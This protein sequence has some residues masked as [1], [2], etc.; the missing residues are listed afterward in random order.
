MYL[1]PNPKQIH[2]HSIAPQKHSTAPLTLSIAPL[3]I[4]MIVRLSNSVQHTLQFDFALPFDPHR[5]AVFGPTYEGRVE[6]AQLLV[7][8]VDFEPVHRRIT[9]PKLIGHEKRRLFSGQLILGGRLLVLGVRL[10]AL[11]VRLLALGVRLLVLG[12]R[13]LALGPRLLIIS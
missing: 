4:P 5:F 1:I 6:V 3:T 12:G 10:I 11:G 8:F 9:L 2:P 13:L 7:H